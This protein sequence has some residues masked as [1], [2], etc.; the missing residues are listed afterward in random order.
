MWEPQ[1]LTTLRPSKACRGE[2]F[3]LP[4]YYLQYSLL[5][6]AGGELSIRAIQNCFS[7]CGYK[8]SDLE[9]PNKADSEN[10]VI[11]KMHH[12]GTYEE[13]SCIVNSL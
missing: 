7:H 6:T 10:D 4:F 3:T 13:F 8:H 9:M 12:V 11:L 5:P 2:N 1:P